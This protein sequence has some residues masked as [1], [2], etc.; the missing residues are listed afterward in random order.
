MGFINAFEYSK[1]WIFYVRKLSYYDKI[2]SNF[3]LLKG[4]SY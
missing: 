3:K 1:F 4:L 2:N